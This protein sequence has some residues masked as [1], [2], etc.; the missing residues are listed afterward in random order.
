MLTAN[1]NTSRAQ[2]PVTIGTLDPDAEDPQATF[3]EAGRFTP[4]TPIT[5]ITGQPAISLPLHA[6]EDGLPI[7]VQLIGRPTGEATLL[8]LA[9]QLE[10]ARPWA[11]R[12][13]PV[14]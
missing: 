8:A 11:D 1:V 2:A 12:R 3:R 7:G 9:T 5:N 14:A 6:R 13:A 4:F 10:T